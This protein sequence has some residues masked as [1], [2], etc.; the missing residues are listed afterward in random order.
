MISRIIKQ[1]LKAKLKD[2]KATII[3]GARQ[4]GKSTLLK[5][6][7]DNEKKISSGMEMKQ[8][9]ENGLKSQHLLN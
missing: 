7:F 2:N 5:S 9:L 8:I 1:N 6:L 3:L 4:V